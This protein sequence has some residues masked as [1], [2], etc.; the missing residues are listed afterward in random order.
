MN[1]NKLYDI[2]QVNHQ[3]VFT[4]EQLDRLLQDDS[5]RLQTAV[6]GIQHFLAQVPIFRQRYPQHFEDNFPNIQLKSYLKIYHIL[7]GIDLDSFSKKEF[8]YFPDEIS[9]IVDA[10]SHLLIYFETQEDYLKCA[11]V[12]KLQDIVL[13]SAF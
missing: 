5:V 4:S 13:N 6:V 3:E 8:N 1:I 11:K 10:L 9:A 7:D 2:F 12:K